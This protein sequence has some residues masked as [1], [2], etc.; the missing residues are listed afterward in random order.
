[1]NAT[2][3]DKYHGIVFFDQVAPFEIATDGVGDEEEGMPYNDDGDGG[4]Q[5]QTLTDL[6]SM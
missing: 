5:M 1:M 4:C 6:R 2:M 3:R